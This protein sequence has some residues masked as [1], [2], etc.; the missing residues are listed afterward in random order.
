VYA[1]LLYYGQEGPTLTKQAANPCSSATSSN[2]H[3]ILITQN[4]TR[5][6]VV[7]NQRLKAWSM[8]QPGT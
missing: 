3:L 8:A 1:S 4:W 2:M 6:L 5:G 7:R